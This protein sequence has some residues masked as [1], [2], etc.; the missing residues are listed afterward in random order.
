MCLG[1]STLFKIVFAHLLHY[2]RTFHLSPVS[3]VHYIGD[4]VASLAY[5]IACNFKQSPS[6][7]TASKIVVH[8]RA[9]KMRDWKMRDWKIR[10]QETYG[11]PRVE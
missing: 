8:I 6:T 9:L 7:T 5:M 1:L 4:I 3:V 2:T 11:T 10:E